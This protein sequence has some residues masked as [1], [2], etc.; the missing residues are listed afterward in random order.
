VER[1]SIDRNESSLP[2]SFKGREGAAPNQFSQKVPVSFPAAR[3]RKVSDPQTFR[4]KGAIPANIKDI[5]QND[6]CEFESSRPRRPVGLKPRFSADRRPTAGGTSTLLAA[7]SRASASLA[8]AM[9]SRYVDLYSAGARAAA[10]RAVQA[11]FAALA[12][13][14]TPLLRLGDEP[15]DRPITV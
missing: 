7:G 9:A 11:A 6:I 3:T 1:S 8:A 10:G 4:M 15:Q 13:V 2:A 5:R 12:S 14:L